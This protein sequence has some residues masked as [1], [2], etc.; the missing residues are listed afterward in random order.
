MSVV[1]SCADIDVF[2]DWTRLHHI[3]YSPPLQQDNLLKCHKTPVCEHLNSTDL[4]AERKP[5]DNLATVSTMFQQPSKSNTGLN[6]DGCTKTIKR[7]ERVRQDNVNVAFGKLREILPTHPPNKKL[8]KCQ[9]L[10]LAVKYIN[11]LNNVLQELDECASSTS[12]NTPE[13]TC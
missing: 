8:S 5:G 10:R 11:L 9:I 3:N 6:L 7:R 1:G 2:T 13:E 4:F 12:Y